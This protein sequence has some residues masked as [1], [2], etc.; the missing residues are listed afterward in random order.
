[1]LDY[2]VAPCVMTRGP[3]EGKK[4]QESPCQRDA[5]EQSLRHQL[6]L[7]NWRKGAGGHGM[8]A[9]SRIWKRQENRFPS[10]QPPEDN[11]ALQTP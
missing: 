2:L 7:R 1:M 10:P 8:G 11:T 4:R 3:Y 6:W 9:A 5:I